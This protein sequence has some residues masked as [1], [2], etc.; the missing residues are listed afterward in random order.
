LAEHVARIVHRPAR[1]VRDGL[2]QIRRIVRVR[3]R[4]RVAVDEP[5]L[6]E[7]RTYT[8]GRSGSVISSDCAY[9]HYRTAK[10]PR[11]SLRDRQ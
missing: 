11:S 10:P 9:T 4:V 1:R 5:R 2:R 3:R 8:L 6:R 7:Q